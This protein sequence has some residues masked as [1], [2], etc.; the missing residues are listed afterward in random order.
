MIDRLACKLAEG[1]A[2][3]HMPCAGLQISV[4]ESICLVL[5]CRSACTRARALCW[6]ADWRAGVHLLGA[7]LHIDVHACAWDVQA[8]RGGILGFETR[9]MLA[10]LMYV[11]SLQYFG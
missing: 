3:E 1:R 10:V 4:H 8:F 9:C 5:A 7:G 6:L 2:H 11:Q